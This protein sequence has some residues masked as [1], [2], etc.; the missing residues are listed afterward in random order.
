M[1]LLKQPVKAPGKFITRQTDRNYRLMIENPPL[2]RHKEGV[3]PVIEAEIPALRRLA[4]S[5]RFRT[6][7]FCRTFHRNPARY[8]SGQ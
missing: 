1:V 6:Y 7:I 8:R 3:T 2:P 5:R 4:C